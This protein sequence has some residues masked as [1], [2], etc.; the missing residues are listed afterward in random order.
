MST[1]WPNWNE[2]DEFKGVRDADCAA[3][4]AGC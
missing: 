4:D 1:S 2:G 3:S